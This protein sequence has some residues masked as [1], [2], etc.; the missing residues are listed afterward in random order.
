[1]RYCLT[2]GIMMTI[3]M[4]CSVIDKGAQKLFLERSGPFEVTVYPVHVVV[5]ETTSADTSLQ[6]E[7]VQYLNDSGLAK[8]VASGGDVD[9]P[10]EWGANQAKMYRRSAEAFAAAVQ[11]DKPATSYAL[12]IETLSMGVENNMGGV[13]FYLVDTA[14]KVVAGTLSN[15]HWEEFKSISPKDRK[16][17][18][19]VA[20]TLLKT[21]TIET[22]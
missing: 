5:S 21:L 10:F 6:K 2:L 12:L 18:M 14:G 15:S 3:L 1:M 17:G 9:I 19:Q 13:H 7:L 22:P 20:Y 11:L 4:S 8:A 16:A